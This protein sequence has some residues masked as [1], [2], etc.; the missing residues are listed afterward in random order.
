MIN[1]I[2]SIVYNNLK[3]TK[4]NSK[5]NSKGDVKV[6]D[7]KVDD[8]KGDDVKGD[9]KN[10]NI[11]KEDIL[12][13]IKESKGFNILFLGHCFSNREKFKTPITAV[14]TGLCLNAYIIT[15]EAIEKLLNKKDD[16]SVPIDHETEILCKNELCYLSNTISN[17]NYGEG[18][19]KQENHYT[20]TDLKRKINLKDIFRILN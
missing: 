2:H 1:D 3:A 4:S 16:Y 5:V 10:N 7:V 12:E 6:E 19:I 18:I 9:T 8:V 17:N 13:R 15:K 20:N 11:T 14:G